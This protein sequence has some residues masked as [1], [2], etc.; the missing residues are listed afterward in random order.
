MSAIAQAQRSKDAELRRWSSTGH[1]E[2]RPNQQ[3]MHQRDP[4]SLLP[5]PSSATKPAN[6]VAPKPQ[7]IAR[8]RVRPRRSH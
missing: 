4:Q 2:A 8:N 3:P 1:R 7:I 5:L 6:S